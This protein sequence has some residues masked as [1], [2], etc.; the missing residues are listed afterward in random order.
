MKKGLTI[1]SGGVIGIFIILLVFSLLLIRAPDPNAEEGLFVISRTNQEETKQ[2]LLD[3]GYLRNRLSLPI[4]R[5][6]TFRF[7][8][9][10]PGGYKLSKAM[11]ARKL[12]SILTSEPQLKWI[13]IPEGLR[14]EEIGE[15]L[16]KELHWSDVDL[17]K[18][19]TTYTAMEY[20]YREGVY[21]PIHILSPLTRMAYLLPK[22]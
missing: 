6:L 19:N 8:E 3:G 16:A 14:K 13:T 7:G 21:F 17:K 12:I 10:E 15:R 9:I 5:V 11:N 2:R 18:W 1:I 20:D 22:E 4:A